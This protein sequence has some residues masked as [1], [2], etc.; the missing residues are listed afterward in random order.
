MA[1]LYES[2][3]FTE[4]LDRLLAG[5]DTAP[6]AELNADLRSALEFARQMKTLRPAPSPAFQANLKARLLVKINENAAAEKS[7]WFW[8]LI[9]REPVWQA[10]AVLLVIVV[11]GVAIW[12]AHFRAGDGPPIAQVTTTTT[13]ATMTATTTATATTTMTST[14]ATATSTATATMTATT[15][16]TAT[17]TTTSATMTATTTAT[18]TMTTTTTPTATSTSPAGN[19]LAVSA[20]TDK[21]AYAAGQPVNIQVTLQ[22]VTGQPFTIK[23][24]PPYLS[25]MRSADKLPV[26]TFS[27]GT[28]DL[29]LAPGQ[30]VTFQ[31][32][33]FQVD[34]KGNAVS[35]GTYYLELEDI[36]YQGQALHLKL[37]QPVSFTIY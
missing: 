37:S 20:Q 2:D 10:A 35:P 11:V 29:T 27:R 4:K 30:Q 26:Y 17:A 21:P 9:P 36:D 16:A 19:Y 24:Y 23:Q 18:A 1:K 34:A 12:G 22:N 6:G 32:Y 3:V 15:T 33:W 14:T 31:D 13:T 28:G 8:R 25:L 5:E 7:G